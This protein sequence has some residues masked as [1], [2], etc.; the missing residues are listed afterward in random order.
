MPS[1]DLDI[2]FTYQ[3]Q[4]KIRFSL[5]QRKTFNQANFH[6]ILDPKFKQSEDHLESSE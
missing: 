2:L 4:W 6:K 3:A 5:L 1:Y